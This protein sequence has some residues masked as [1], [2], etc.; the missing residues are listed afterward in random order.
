VVE[1]RLV[2]SGRTY[3]IVNGQVTVVPGDVG[4]LLG[5]G[6][7]LGQGPRIN[8][9]AGTTYTVLPSDNGAILSFTNGGAITL[10]VPSGLSTE[11]SCGIIQAGAG[12]VTPTAATGVTISNR[13]SQTKTAGQYA[14]MSLT[15]IAQDIYILAG[16]G[17]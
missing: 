1:G 8:T 11:F 10:T 12:Q 9:I 13:Q 15:S 3:S 6:F 14:F 5:Y 17:A 4:T 2:P 7:W 16:D